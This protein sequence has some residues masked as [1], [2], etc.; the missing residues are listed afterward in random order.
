MMAK[1]RNYPNH[2]LFRLQIEK[3]KKMD[4]WKIRN[5]YYMPF[6]VFYYQDKFFLIVTTWVK[7]NKGW[8]LYK[9]VFAHMTSE[10]K[11]TSFV[12][13]VYRRFICCIFV[14]ERRMFQMKVEENHYDWFHFYFD[15]VNWTSWF[16]LVIKSQCKYWY[17]IHII[18]FTI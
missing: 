9:K 10:F 8:W 15:G 4:G 6:T 1:R 14:A 7:N 17:N 18:M 2:R 12:F 3:K 16:I 5:E 13:M 11:A